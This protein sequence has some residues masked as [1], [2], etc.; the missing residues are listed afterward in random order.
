MKQRSQNLN[1]SWRLSVP[2]PIIPVEEEHP[3][4][5][6]RINWRTVWLI[7]FLSFMLNLGLQAWDKI[8]RL[9]YR[10]DLGVVLDQIQRQT[11]PEAQEEQRNAINEIIITI[12][13]NTREAFQE[14][15]DALA[16]EVLEPGAVVVTDNCP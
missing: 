9:A 4:L 3:Q 6:P 15:L 13:C 1:P 10:D 12:D 11:S 5:P 16:D 7:T 8:D 2:N 14:A